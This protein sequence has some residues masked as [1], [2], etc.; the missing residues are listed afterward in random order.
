MMA[1]PTSAG[2]AQ[3]GVILMTRERSVWW[4]IESM[5]YH[6]PNMVSCKLINRLTRTPL[7]GA[8][9]PLSTLDHL[10]DLE[11]YL[12]RFKYPIVL[13]DL[14]ADLDKARSLQIQKMADLLAE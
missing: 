2:G 6:G 1:R 13:G 11:E 12:K 8:Y 4:D 7:V 5:R 14:N 9:L 10:P 3:G